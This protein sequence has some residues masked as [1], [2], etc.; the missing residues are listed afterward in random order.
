MQAV[1]GLRKKFCRRCTQMHADE[2][3]TNELSERILDC[4][5][6]VLNT[7]G[8]GF[9]EKIYENVLAYELLEAGIS[10]A[11]QRGI[12]AYDYRIV[13]GDHVAD[14]VVEG[15]VMIELKVSEILELAH[16][17][18]CI[19]Y[20]QAIGVRL[21]LLLHFARSPLKIHRVAH[22]LGVCSVHPRA[23]AEN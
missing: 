20:L 3:R 16:A 9:F 17:A 12:T 22:G 2:I 18:Q 6:C 10:V 13:V 7:L 19:N 15:T 5:F 14:L 8:A 21:C 23:S 11:Q 4:A 1:A